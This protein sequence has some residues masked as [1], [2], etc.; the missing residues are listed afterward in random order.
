MCCV[1]TNHGR[2]ALCRRQQMLLLLCGMLG[3][4]ASPPG[5]HQAV[6]HCSWQGRPT[7]AT[8]HPARQAVHQHCGCSRRAGSSSSRSS[9]AGICQGVMQH[10][11]QTA[12]LVHS[13]ACSGSNNSRTLAVWA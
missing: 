4:A 11:S 1:S 13:A 6:T 2:P 9:L 10:S 5:C 3:L 8:P 12:L 7:S